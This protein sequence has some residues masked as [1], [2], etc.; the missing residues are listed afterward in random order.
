[1]CQFAHIAF[2]KFARLLENFILR[3]MT[4]MEHETVFICNN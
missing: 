3:D 1:M 4:Q 2:D